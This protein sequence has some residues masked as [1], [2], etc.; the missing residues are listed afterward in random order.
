MAA[1]RKGGNGY[2]QPSG[3]PGFPAIPSRGTTRT[4]PAEAAAVSAGSTAGRQR[5]P[6]AGLPY[7]PVDRY[8]GKPTSPSPP[9]LPPG[10]SSP[11]IERLPRKPFPPGPAVPKAEPSGCKTRIRRHSKR[12]TVQRL[13]VSCV[14]PVT[15]LT[16]RC[17]Y[18]RLAYPLY[19]YSTC[20]LSPFALSPLDCTTGPL[21]PGV[22]C[23]LCPIYTPRT[24]G[25]HRPPLPFSRSNFPP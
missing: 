18:S 7:P 15:L 4:G 13:A 2:R 14:F 21:F 10:A 8:P 22:D 5:T 20:P 9:S 19:L 25:R 17:P 12:P 11:A 23:P 24:D 1:G 16:R 6:R 3:T